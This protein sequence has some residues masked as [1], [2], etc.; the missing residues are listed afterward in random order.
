MSVWRWLSTPAEPRAIYAL[1]CGLG[2]GLL[3]LV[4]APIWIGANIIAIGVVGGVCGGASSILVKV[5][6]ERRNA[7]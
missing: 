1:L 3:M 4:S 2:T 7:R 6:M 5:L